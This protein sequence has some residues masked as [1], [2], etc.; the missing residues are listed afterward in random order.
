V[1]RGRTLD[2][3]IREGALQFVQLGRRQKV[4]VAELE[5]F[6]QQGEAPREQSPPRVAKK[7]NPRRSPGVPAAHYPEP[8]WDAEIAKARTVRI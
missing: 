7:R 1:S 2:R 4:T 6:V 8:D 3:L 5:R